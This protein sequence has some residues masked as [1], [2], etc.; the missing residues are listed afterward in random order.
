VKPAIHRNHRGLEY[1]PPKPPLCDVPVAHSNT[2]GMPIKH[3]V[4]TFTPQV[5]HRFQQ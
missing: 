3:K 5:D 4:A 1:A 2:I